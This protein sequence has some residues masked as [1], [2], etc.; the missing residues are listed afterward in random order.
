MSYKH[1]FIAS[2]IRNNPDD[3]TG[4]LIQKAINAYEKHIQNFM[5]DVFEI[6]FG[7]DAI[8]KE[9]SVDEVLE[10]LRGFCED[11]IEKD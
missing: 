8:N 6:A 10:A 11:S 5:E 4:D 2:F 1:E 3:I 9:Y 7:D